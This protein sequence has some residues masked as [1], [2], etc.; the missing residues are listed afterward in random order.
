MKPPLMDDP[1][2]PLD[3]L[4]SLWPETVSVFLRHKMLCVGCMVA[5][6]HTV[7]DACREYDLD[8]WVFRAELHAAVGI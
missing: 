7:I 1:E 2:M 3:T 6:F 8:E 5:S 4:M